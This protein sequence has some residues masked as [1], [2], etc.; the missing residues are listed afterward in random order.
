MRWAGAQADPSDPKLPNGVTTLASHVKAPPQL[1]RRLAQIGVVD[2]AEGPR[3][4]ALLKPGQRFVSRE[5]D[6]W[7]WDGFVVAAHAPTG[8][9]RR[10]A[11]RGR[12]QAIDGELEAARADVAA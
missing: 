1:A 3:L 10:L 8:A 5:G 12:L 7:R 11:E 6:F 2:R 4:A 9:A